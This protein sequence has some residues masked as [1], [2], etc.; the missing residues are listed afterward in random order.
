M[1]VG[2]PNRMGGVTG[3][4]KRFVKRLDA[5]AWR[6]RPMAMFATVAKP[7][8]GEV[9]EKQKQSYEKWALTAAPKLRD[10]AKSR[11]LNAVDLVLAVAV[12]DQKGPLVDD[13]VEKT[14]QFAHEFLQT[15]KK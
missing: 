1:F 10:L 3:R 2:S 6:G 11:G 8:E 13:G 14:K 5:E 9:T 15:L 12:K 4:T 7:P